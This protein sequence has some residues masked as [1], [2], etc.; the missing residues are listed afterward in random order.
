M[1]FVFSGCPPPDFHLGQFHVV[2]G[3]RRTGGD[4]KKKKAD[5]RPS[6]PETQT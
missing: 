6:N 1:L 4:K 5:G 2:V 3:N